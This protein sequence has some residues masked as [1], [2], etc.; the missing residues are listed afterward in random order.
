MYYDYNFDPTNMHKPYEKFVIFKL[1]LGKDL[2]DSAT[3]VMRALIFL[4]LFIAFIFLIPVLV[5][6]VVHT[7]NFMANKASPN[8]KSS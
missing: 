6:F 4:L 2:Y 1:N 7:K 8:R 5:L 3:I